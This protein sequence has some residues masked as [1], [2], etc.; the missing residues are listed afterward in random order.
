MFVT[1]TFVMFEILAG[2]I[3][4]IPVI[5]FLAFFGFVVVA[6]R[7]TNSDHSQNHALQQ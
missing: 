3:V 2:M 5:V 4:T 7:K 6:G 1:I